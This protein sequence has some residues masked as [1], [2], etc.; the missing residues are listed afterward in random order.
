MASMW[1]TWI[2]KCE[3]IFYEY[4]QF[5]NS[6]EDLCEFRLIRQNLWLQNS[7]HNTNF[8]NYIYAIVHILI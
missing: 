6:S 1:V 8:Q 4:S 7:H 5:N 3:T 2:G